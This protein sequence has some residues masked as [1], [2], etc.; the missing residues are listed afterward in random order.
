MMNLKKRMRIFKKKGRAV[1][2]VQRKMI[3]R[4]RQET[5]IKEREILK[6]M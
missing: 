4:K 6:K 1:K 5:G 2:M 3:K